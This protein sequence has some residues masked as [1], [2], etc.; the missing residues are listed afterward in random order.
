MKG[1]GNAR[2]VP[3]RRQLR[4]R[5]PRE[6]VIERTA[7]AFGVDRSSWAPGRRSDDVGRAIA[8]ELACRL[9]PASKRQIADAL[10]YKSQ[11][12]LTR[13]QARAATARQ[14]ASIRRKLSRLEKQLTNH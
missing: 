5:V 12:S 1:R 7:E 6:A 3:Q 8:A 14:S 13:A 10:G 2:N 11:S 4:R 9:C